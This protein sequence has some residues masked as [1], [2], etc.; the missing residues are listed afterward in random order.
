MG[1]LVNN[2]NALDATEPYDVCVI[3]AGVAGIVLGVRFVQ[4]GLRVLL[5]ESGGSQRHWMLD[6]RL[7]QLGSLDVGGD[8]QYPRESATPRA[9]GGGSHVWSGIC[10]RFEPGDFG[11]QPYM[12]AENPWPLSYADLERHYARV[13]KLFRVRGGSRRS[14]RERPLPRLHARRADTAF[15]N[16]VEQSGVTVR[17]AAL[18]TPS[19]DARVFD[20]RRELLPELLASRTGTLV[21][22]VTVTRLR[23]DRNGRVVGATCRTL[24]GAKKF[25]RAD[26]FIVC[27]GS[28]QTPRLLLLSR[29]ARFPFGIGNDFDRVGRGFNDQGILTI[30]SEAPCRPLLQRPRAAHAQQCH[31]AFRR[32][33]LGAVYPVFSQAPRILEPVAASDEDR[34]LVHWLQALRAPFDPTLTLKCRIETKP[35]DSNRVTLSRATVDSLGDPAAHLFFDYSAE[36]LALIGKTRAMMHRWLD[37]CGAERHVDGGL[38]WAGAAAGTC[39]MG[40]DPRASV[41]DATLRVHT[42]PNL[43]LCGAETFPVG[44]ALPPALTIAAFAD[45]LASHVVARAR[46]CSRAAATTRTRRRMPSEPAP[47][48]AL[49][50]REPQS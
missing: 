45:R 20:L 38:T 50:R 27:C 14:P 43:Y 10:E 24:D 39:R 21:S 19:R 46:W 22:G 28:V 42:S 17:P 16:L 26:T 13:E 1:R 49:T 12:P 3:G 34:G 37:R 4:A 15:Q 6:A 11:A 44:A 32:H 47:T 33:G 23:A 31:R 25:A 2:L 41:C 40:T 35:A 7:K 9:V 30:R 18:A 8:T 48:V 36:D 29:S 5:L